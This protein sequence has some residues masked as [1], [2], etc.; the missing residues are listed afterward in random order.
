MGDCWK[1]TPDID[2][3]SPHAITHMWNTHT[4]TM[5]LNFYQE[6]VLKDPN[7]IINHWLEYEIHKEKLEDKFFPC[8][9]VMFINL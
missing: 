6:L 3:W 4:Y 2:L 7:T 5:Y 1:K 9:S 8:I